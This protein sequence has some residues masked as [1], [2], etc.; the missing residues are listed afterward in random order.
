MSLEKGEVSM[1]VPEEVRIGAPEED[2]MGIPE[3][4][5]MGIP[6]E[7]MGAPEEASPMGRTMR[8]GLVAASVAAGGIHI[9]AAVQHA[10]P[11]LI[12]QLVFFVAV[13]TMQLW[14]RPP[15]S[16]SET[17]RGRC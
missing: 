17:S 1:R 15:S 11:R 9:W 6:E 4:D 5:T 16:G 2:M 10:H 14:W 12:T 7:D 3:E 13:A 8:N